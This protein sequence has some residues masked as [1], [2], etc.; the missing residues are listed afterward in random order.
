MGE[1]TSIEFECTAQ[2]DAQY[3][4]GNFV[5]SAGSYSYEGYTGLWEGRETCVTFIAEGN[6]VR[7][8]KIVVTFDCAAVMPPVIRPASGTYYNPIEV[9]MTC[10]TSG[11]HIYYTLDFV[12]WKDLNTPPANNEKAVDEKNKNG[13]GE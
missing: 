1:I 10:P 13:K 2:D 6:Q 8:T 7:L 4:P 3:G 12:E 9:T 5:T 11:A